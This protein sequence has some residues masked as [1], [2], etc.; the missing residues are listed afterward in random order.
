LILGEYRRNLSP[1]GQPGSGDAF[2]KWLWNNQGNHDHCRRVNI[3]PHDNR[4][5]AEF[6]DD[7]ELEPFDNDDRK[8]VAVA[9]ASHNA[10]PILNATDSDWWEHRVALEGHGIRIKSL[11]PELMEDG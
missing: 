1:S 11:C 2:F 9:L 10:P 7:P 5:F 3:T 8:F 4:G 6:P